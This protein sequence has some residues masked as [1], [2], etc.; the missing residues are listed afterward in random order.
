MAAERRITSDELIDYNDAQQRAGDAM[1]ELTEQLKKLREEKKAAAAGREK[2]M[3]EN[4]KLRNIIII[5][6]M[7]QFALDILMSYENQFIES[8][9]KRMQ[10]QN[11][12]LLDDTDFTFLQLA[13]ISTK[14]KIENDV[15]N[16][17][18]AHLFKKIHS[19]TNHKEVKQMCVETMKR[20]A[21]ESPHLVEGIRNGLMAEQM[22]KRIQHHWYNYL[23]ETNETNE[24]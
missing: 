19:A 3:G 15:Q 14:Q 11:K 8:V 10:K 6:G 7:K 5:T 21:E 23:A 17:N 22:I 16:I 1:R 9:A 20:I 24:L 18:A 2:V 13:H 4:K 12:R